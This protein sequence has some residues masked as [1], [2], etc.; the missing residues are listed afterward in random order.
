MCK[1]TKWNSLHQYYLMGFN[2]DLIFL[3]STLSISRMLCYRLSFY[4][5]LYP[6]FFYLLVQC[7]WPNVFSV[8]IINSLFAARCARWVCVS[9]CDALVLIDVLLYE[10]VYVGGQKHK[11][12]RWRRVLRITGIP[13]QGK[14][15]SLWRCN[16]FLLFKVCRW[17]WS[18][19]L[20]NFFFVYWR[21][22]DVNWCEY[23]EMII[24]FFW[25]I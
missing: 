3:L 12:V 25:E 16:F 9:V 5:L 22:F 8:Y 17:W 24:L 6:F 2:T 19:D 13:R 11:K 15:D 18:Q 23:Y 4:C 7:T 14:L 1:H 10:R 21:D 20:I